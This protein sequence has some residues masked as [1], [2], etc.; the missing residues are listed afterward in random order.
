[1][2]VTAPKQFK[3]NKDDGSYLDWRM[4]VIEAIHR[5]PLSIMDKI[6]LLGTSVKLD[7]KE[8]LRQIFNAGTHT[9][10]AYKRILETLESQYGGDARAYAYLRDQM[11][12]MPGFDL[13]NLNSVTLIRTKVEK[14]MEFVRIHQ[15]RQFA[16]PDNK[17]LL[18][19]VLS[20]VLTKSQVLLFRK[21]CTTLN[22]GGGNLH[23]LRSLADWL[24][25]EEGL[26]Q[27][28]DQNHNPNLMG[29]KKGTKVSAH[30]ITTGDSSGDESVSPNM[31]ALLAK[32]NA[33]NRSE[34]ASRFDWAEDDP[35]EDINDTKSL[36]DSKSLD[37]EPDDG[38]GGG[39]PADGAPSTDLAMAVVET[40][41]ATCGYCKKARHLVSKCEE[42]RQLP[43]S[44][45]YDFCKKDN[46]CGNCLSPRH[47]TR[48]CPS[49]YR[50]QECGK[51]HHTLLHYKGAPGQSSAKA[52]Q[53]AKKSS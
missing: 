22:I 5:Q 19:L 1:M 38:D 24:K 49:T 7:G 36:D 47:N 26:L 33:D 42:F 48:K 44:A 45:R 28:A 6:H 20:N 11:I 17:T 43:V 14:F 15:L 8:S 3:G 2:L 34:L 53:P 18:E 12:S 39:T 35:N 50:C 41:L 9:P 10:E 52:G 31:A 37:T 4:M 21:T 16:K 32:G 13:K 40:K 30:K 51:K 29:A 23:N 46:R 25:Y 27:W